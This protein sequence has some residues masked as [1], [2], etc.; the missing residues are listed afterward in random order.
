[1]ISVQK[2]FFYKNKDW[3]CASTIFCIAA[4][5]L[6]ILQAAVLNRLFDVIAAE[7]MGKLPMMVEL[8]LFYAAVMALLTFGK[9]FCMANF[10]RNAVYHLRQEL[11]DGLLRMNI[12]DFQKTSSG[13]YASLLTNDVTSVQTNYFALFFE[14]VS[15]LVSI[16]AALTYLFVMNWMVAIVAI[17]CTL[18]PT[19]YGSLFG[20]KL[21][22]MQTEISDFSGSYTTQL[23]DIFGG[24]EVVKS[25][26]IEITAQR[27]HDS[28][29]RKLEAAKCHQGVFMGGMYGILNFVSVL[30]QFAVIL[31]AGYLTVKGRFTVGNIVAVTNLTGLALQPAMQIGDQFG[32]LPT[33]IRMSSFLR[34]SRRNGCKA[35]FM[36]RVWTWSLK[37]SRR[38]STHP[39]VKTG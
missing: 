18:M 7:D 31:F 27:N 37:S 30:L 34:T 10:Q 2:Y 16:A 14:I 21:S 32:R 12:S 13:R 29:A 22:K 35:A 6:A 20:K 36:Q 8:V 15:G 9:R 11:A 3:F 5:L 38:V 4:S 33:C 25:Y 28:Q 1:M 17:V 26:L 39:F 24:F 23:Q 19:L